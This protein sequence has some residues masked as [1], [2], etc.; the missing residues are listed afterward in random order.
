MARIGSF[1]TRAQDLPYRD[2]G[3]G[4]GDRRPAVPAFAKAVLAAVMHGAVPVARATGTGDWQCAR[5]SSRLWSPV[6][7]LAA[8]EGEIALPGVP[9]FTLVITGPTSTCGNC[10]AVQIRTTP[11]VSREL[12]GL[13]RETWRAAGIRTGFR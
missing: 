13:L 10:G 1:E 8:V 4:C 9:A 2:C 12:A 5:C 7:R 6:R 11:G 3:G